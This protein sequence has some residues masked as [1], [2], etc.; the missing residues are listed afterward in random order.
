MNPVQRYVE[1]MFLNLPNH[2]NVQALK[3]EV[4]R[5][6]TERY[7]IFMSEGLSP[8]EA[9][10]KVIIELETEEE[11]ILSNYHKNQGIDS[12]HQEVMSLSEA[13]E[14]INLNQ[15][16]SR[17][18]GRAIVYILLSTGLISTFNAFG[19]VEWGVLLMFTII[20]L[21]VSM[22]I[23]AGMRM[24]EHFAEGK[25]REIFFE[26]QDDLVLQK[27]FKAFKSEERYRIALG[28]ALCIV[29]VVPLLA[30]SFF[31]NEF[32]IEAAGVLILLTLIGLGVYQ[33]IQYGMAYSAY[34][35]V[36]NIGEYSKENLEYE[37]KLEPIAGIYWLVIVLLYLT[38]SFLT[39][40]WHI[41]WVIWPLAGIVWAIVSL[42]IKLFRKN[43]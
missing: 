19:L 14:F 22:M 32:L 6:S 21:S 10:A 41:S 2:D 20:A 31:D 11:K 24:D 27:E 28:V 18:I 33:F 29:A 4:S 38:W 42:V 1:S 34:E 8:Q 7:E 37:R 13:R 26:N 23:M 3:E 17:R 40:D 30:F 12:T 5:D 9:L 25:H 15:T 35:R 39:M 43:E 36:L 16:E